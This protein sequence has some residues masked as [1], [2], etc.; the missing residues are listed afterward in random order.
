MTALRTTRPG[1]R[2]PTESESRMARE[3]SRRLGSVVSDLG[4]PDGDGSEDSGAQVVVTVK[5]RPAGEPLTIP[6]AAL[7][8]LRLILDE[9]AKGNAITLTPVHAEL[10]TQEAADLLCVSRPFLIKL[11]EDGTI[12][13]RKVGRHRRIRFDDLMPYK[14]RT[15]AARSEVLDELVA[16]AQELGM[17]Y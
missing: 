1:L 4:K 12:P 3:S 15:D 11:V 5:G 7:K 8:L 13:H 16:Q 2:R 14:Q 6:L 17:G 10:T 9:M